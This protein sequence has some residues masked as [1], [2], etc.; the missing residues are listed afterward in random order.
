MSEQKRHCI[1]CDFW[2][3]HACTRFASQEKFIE[4]IISD[5]KV[6]WRLDDYQGIIAVESPCEIS[7]L[8]AVKF[9]KLINL[10]D[11]KLGQWKFAKW[12]KNGCKVLETPSGEGDSKNMSGLQGGA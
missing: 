10:Q 2:L 3:E 7:R 9:K 5:N 4:L 8:F 12:K 6:A 11:W 1:L